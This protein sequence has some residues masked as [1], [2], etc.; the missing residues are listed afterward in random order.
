MIF[1]LYFT[2]INESRLSCGFWEMRAIS[3]KCFPVL[4]KLC[5]TIVTINYDVLKSRTTIL[6]GV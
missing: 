2:D 5:I 6:L 3:L 1:V 4:A